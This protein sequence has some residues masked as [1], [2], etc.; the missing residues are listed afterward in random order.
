MT[1]HTE[2]VK[3]IP[4]TYAKK[5]KTV[6][7]LAQHYIS[8]WNKTRIE[9]K[10]KDKQ[11]IIP[12]TICF[13][14][15]IGVGA[16]EIADILSE[17]IGYR[18]VDRQIIEQIAKEG[19]L[20]EKTVAYFDERYPGVRNE[21]ISL[22]IGEKS[23]TMSDYFKHLTNVV[24]SIAAM[25]PT[26]FVGRGTHCILPRDRVLAVRF[27]GSRAFRVKRLAKIL[28]VS[29]IEAER[30]LDEVDKE[31]KNFFKKILGKK[32]APA[33]EFDL[34]INCDYL[35]KPEWGA[36]IVRQA[37]KEKFYQEIGEKLKE[38]NL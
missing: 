19:K 2:G 32:D 4:G 1:K 15:K 36:N 34:V 8:D 28:K 27:I 37:F 30:T 25:E 6:A 33:Y 35:Q 11:K 38:E 29:A 18:V 7:Q 31:Q 13:S 21:F 24:F 9:I 23:F 3:Y 26:I 20:R 12:P 10:A 5:R 22:M 14:R 17:K 16:L